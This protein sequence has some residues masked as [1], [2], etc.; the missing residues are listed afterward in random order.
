MQELK[1]KM[2][3]ELLE[4]ILPFWMNHAVDRENGGF[5]GK[6]HNDLFVE[7]DAPKG[8]VLNARIL[9]T[10]S[11]AYRI[12]GR[13]EYLEIAQRAFNY[14]RNFFIDAES[15]GIFWLIDYTGNPIETRKQVYA[16]AFMIYAFSE[17]YRAV[18]DKYALELAVDLYSL[19]E[20]Y[21]YDPVYK[22]YF[23][24]C[25]REWKIS[26]FCLDRKCGEEKK[27]MNTMLHIMEAYTNLYRVWKDDRL[28][29][30]LEETVE[31]MM[32]RI[33]DKE[34]GHF[35]LFFDERWRSLKKEYS[36]GHDIEG[37]W[38]LYE[39]AG[40]AG[41]A[42]LLQRT[43]RI[44]IRMAE[45]TLA[46]GLDSDGSVMYEGGP[47]GVKDSDRHWWPQAE[48]VVGFANAYGLTGKHEFLDAAKD[49]WKYTEEKIID[50]EKG[51]WY[52]GITRDGRIMRPDSKVDFWKCP[53]HNARACMEMVERVK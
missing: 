53:Y 26:N 44:A 6:I 22:G 13:Q 35:K 12:Y 49:V 14:I 41:N 27:S 39:A 5:Y 2:E 43:G 24:A 37:S 23:E 46:E 19:I 30:K 38:L 42:V 7:K 9:W 8:G 3:K 4:N 20:K 45:S 25:N 16:Q 21:C 15:G 11:A 50:H 36:Y 47:E 31:V 34:T 51:E 18:L 28:K 40:V 10:F 29:R 33:V 17:Y 48:A 1:I 52:W 32:E